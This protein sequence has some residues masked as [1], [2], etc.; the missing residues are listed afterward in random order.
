MEV[1]VICCAYENC[2]R[3]VFIDCFVTIQGEDCDL[4]MFNSLIKYR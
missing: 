1:R 2:V 3:M 4:N